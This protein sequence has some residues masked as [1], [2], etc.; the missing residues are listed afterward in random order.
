[1][2]K[3]ESKPKIAGPKATKEFWEVKELKNK[4][5]LSRITTLFGFVTII[6]TVIGYFLN[7][8]ENREQRV[9]EERLR[10][11]NDRVSR[12]TEVAIEFDEL[13]GATLSTLYDNELRLSFL[14]FEL[15]ALSEELEQ[16]STP[17]KISKILKKNVDQLYDKLN[18]EETWPGQFRNGAL[19]QERWRIKKQALS[20][21]FD[22]LF[23]TDLGTEWS[24][25]SLLAWRVLNQ[26]FNISSD[27]TPTLD[28]LENKG[29]RFQSQ[30]YQA[31]NTIKTKF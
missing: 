28:S 8:A 7:S 12:M 6:L 29:I 25:V 14:N 16:I 1:M 2:S 10:N 31:I 26:K 15:N 20:P 21:D 18:K 4:I 22:I 9:W 23:G 30:L 19:L 17:T 5:Q 13:F 24:E 11:Q 27:E 3:E